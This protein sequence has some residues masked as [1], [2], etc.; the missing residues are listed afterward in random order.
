MAEKLCFEVMR[1]R[2]ADEDRGEGAPDDA[3]EA[4]SSE[5][6]ENLMYIP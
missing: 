6:L 4:G 5:G 1:G 2:Y 3:E